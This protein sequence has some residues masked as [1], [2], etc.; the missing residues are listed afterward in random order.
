MKLFT[1]LLLLCGL[2]SCGKDS[3]ESKSITT[4]RPVKPSVSTENYFDIV[5]NHRVKIGLRPFIYSPTIAEVAY[6]HSRFMS[7]G[8]GRFGHGGWRNRCSRLRNDMR[9]NLCGEIVAMGQRTPEAVL[10][11]WLNSPEHRSAIENPRY[12]HTG[13]GVAKNQE[14]RLYWTQMFVEL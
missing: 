5:N 1:I 4:I 9:T 6:G 11:A 10:E 14:G 12:T 2:A 7:E 3:S 13:V 8:Y